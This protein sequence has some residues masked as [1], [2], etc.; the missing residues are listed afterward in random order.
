MTLLNIGFGNLVALERILS[1]LNPDSSP[2]KRIVHTSKE[3]GNLIDATCGRKTQSVIIMD[4]GHVVTSSLSAE[5]LSGKI[6]KD[7][8]S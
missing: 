2:V 3:N 6:G 7:T 1:I 8:N 4:N 5:I